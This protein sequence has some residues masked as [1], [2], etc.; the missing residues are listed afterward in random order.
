EGGRFGTV[1]LDR[2]RVAEAAGALDPLDAVRLEEARD[3]LGH[4]VDDAVLPLVRG[5]EVEAGLPD[6]DA[7][8]GEGLLGFLEREGGLHPGLGRDAPDAQAGAAELRLFL[9][10][11]GLGAELCGA[12]R[13]GVAARP[14]AEDGNVTVH[15]GSSRWGSV[16]FG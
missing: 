1:D 16:W 6:L 5:L 13:R 2:V 10:A 8:L 15:S 7:E 12:D 11:D 4:L 3:A 9:Y 14:A